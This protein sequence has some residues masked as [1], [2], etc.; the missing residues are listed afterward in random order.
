MKANM[1]P[2]LSKVLITGASGFIGRALINNLINIGPIGTQFSTR[3]EIPGAQ[4][5]TVDLRNQQEVVELIETVKPTTVFHLAALTSP[6]RNSMDPALAKESHIT[7]TNNILK[8]L[9]KDA[10][11]VYLSTDKVFDGTDSYPDEATKP[12]PCCLYGE[13]KLK[14][15]NMIQYQIK[16]HHIIRLPI[17]HSLGEEASN[18]FIDGALRG[19]MKGEHV[20]TFDNISRCYV[21][22]DELVYFLGLLL[23]DT[24]YGLYHVGT[25]MSSY[26]DRIINLCNDNQIK[27]GDKLFPTKGRVTPSSQN[28]NMGKAKNI[29]NFKFN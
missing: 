23:E 20:S 11:M 3:Q 14:C 27:W 7:V 16:N 13:L 12:N 2:K 21:R 19:L 10:H 26:Y 6:G 24:N 9:P 18:S 17:V 29:F 25:E 22:L 4:M 8:A 28:I 15:E 1:A 5:I